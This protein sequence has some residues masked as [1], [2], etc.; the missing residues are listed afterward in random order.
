MD[1]YLEELMEVPHSTLVDLARANGFAADTLHS[2]E[3]LI[4]A[5]I[6]GIPLESRISKMRR[7][8]HRFIAEQGTQF[9]DTMDATCHKCFKK[10]QQGCF[11]ERA[12][13]D[14]LTNA[15]YLDTEEL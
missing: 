13:L 9:M 11:D 3:Q 7:C 14:F 8:L 15:Q 2:R 5:L 4:G 12:L 10:N 1:E 6:D